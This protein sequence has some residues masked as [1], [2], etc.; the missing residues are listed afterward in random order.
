ML[1]NIEVNPDIH[2]G[3]PYVTGTRITVENVLELINQGLSFQEIITNYY[4]DLTER[5]IHACLQ[6]VIA[7]VSSEEI[8]INAVSA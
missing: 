6:Y 2:F 7:L 4:P 8:H 3:K 1:E 5:D